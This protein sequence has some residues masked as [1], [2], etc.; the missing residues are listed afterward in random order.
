MYVMGKLC[1]LAHFKAGQPG[2]NG[3]SRLHWQEDSGQLITGWTAR[4]ENSYVDNL[5][6][7]SVLHTTNLT[8]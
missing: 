2:L 1:T 3:T 8:I 5:K 7:F 6:L 4:F